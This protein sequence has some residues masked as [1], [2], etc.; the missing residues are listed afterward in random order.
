MLSGKILQTDSV[1]GYIRVYL[2]SAA[3]GNNTN[4]N[5]NGGRNNNNKRAHGRDNNRNKNN[6]KRNTNR[7]CNKKCK[8]DNRNSQNKKPWPQPNKPYLKFIL[9]K[10]MLDTNYA[11]ETLCKIL[12]VF[13]MG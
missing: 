9:Y 6:K 1:D 8:F 3:G 4:N 12:F 7:T 5:C 10:E 2:K 11:I 13:Y